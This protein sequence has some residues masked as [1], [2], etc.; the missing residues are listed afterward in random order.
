MEL[1]AVGVLAVAPI[2]GTHRGLNMSHSRVPGQHTGKPQGY[3]PAP[4][5]NKAARSGSLCPP[6]NAP[7]S[8][9]D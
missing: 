1:E 6:R 8:M 7:K 4:T 5:C 3:V 2:I 9:I